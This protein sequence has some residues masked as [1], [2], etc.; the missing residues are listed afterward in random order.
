M[1][2]YRSSILWRGNG[3]LRGVPAAVWFGVTACAT[4]VLHTSAWT[5]ANSAL[6]SS[7]L[8]K[9]MPQLGTQIKT[10]DTGSI[11]PAD[12]EMKGCYHHQLN[13][14]TKTATQK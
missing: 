12:R 7:A 11:L 4:S 1:R 8:L 5:P 9:R 3:L 2:T 10:H 13:L 6:L 14:N